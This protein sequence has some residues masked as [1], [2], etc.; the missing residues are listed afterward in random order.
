MYTRIIH[1]KCIYC[2]LQIYLVLSNKKKKQQGMHSYRHSALSEISNRIVEKNITAY[3]LISCAI[4]LPM[5]GLQILLCGLRDSLVQRQSMEC[6]LCEDNALNSRIFQ[7]EEPLYPLDG[8]VQNGLKQ[9][10]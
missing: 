6:Q 8:Y 4:F 5:R 10:N 2:A 7:N 3:Y 9:D 1:A